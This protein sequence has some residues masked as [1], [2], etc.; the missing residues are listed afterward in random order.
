MVYN[1]FFQQGLIDQVEL[2]LVAGDYQTDTVVSDFRS[3]FSLV[4]F[5]E[6]STFSFLTYV[7][8]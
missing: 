2:T 5:Q 3:D 6:H 1:A 8:K 7:R 4:S